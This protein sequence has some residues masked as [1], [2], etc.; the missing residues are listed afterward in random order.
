[1]SRQCRYRHIV[2]RSRTSIVT[3][4]AA[5]MRSCDAIFLLEEYRESELSN[6]VGAELQ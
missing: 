6:P 2:Q 4:S 1:M 3:L 5:H